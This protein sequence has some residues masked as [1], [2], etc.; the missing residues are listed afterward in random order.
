MAGVLL[1]HSDPGACPSHGTLPAM[2]SKYDQFWITRLRLLRNGIAAAAAGEAMTIDVTGINALGD[3]RSWSGSVVVRGRV[4]VD[5]T[6]AHTTS[7]GHVV[8]SQGVCDP[9]P[10]LRFRLSVN[11]T[12]TRLTITCL[13]AQEPPPVSRVARRAA[14]PTDQPLEIGRT[15]EDSCAE[16]HRILGS[17]PLYQAPSEVPFTNGLYFFYEEG[18]ASAHGDRIVR[19]GNHPRAQNRLVERLNDHF[20]SRVGAKNFSV[21]RRYLGGSLLRRH[22]PTHVCLTP[23]PGQGHWERQGDSV[24]SRCA[25]VEQEVTELLRARFRFRCIAIDDMSM[26]NDLE[27][28]LIATVARCR[29]CG[30]TSDWLGGHAYPALVRSTGLW[31]TQHVQALPATTKHLSLIERL[32]TWDEPSREPSI[33]GP[34]SQ[35]LLVVPCSGRKEPRLDTRLHEVS[36]GGLLGA[37]ARA[38]LEEGRRRAFAQSKTQL[39]NTSPILP[40]LAYYSGQPYA[41]PG[42]RDGLLQAVQAGVHVLIVSGGYGVLRAEE[43]IHS[44]NAHLGTQTRH[45]WSTRLPHILRDYVARQRITRSLVL[46]STQYAACVPQLTSDEYR[47][48]PTFDRTSD[49]GSAMQAVPAKIG[50]ELLRQLQSLLRSQPPG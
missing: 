33:R 13:D 18:Q 41:T 6:M 3:R 4:V 26:R 50:F 11:A 12:G 5:G 28:C 37:E 44:Y 1:V 23:A 31:N 7:L 22:D 49:K 42:V 20:N 10:G 46:L 15:A 8:G 39:R 2:A 21:F 30:P 32:V 48:V 25:P 40:A 27:K 34:L 36:I 29:D 17:L 14:L 43:P 16:L 45:V 35:T 9:W 38:V 19:I 47:F 24:C